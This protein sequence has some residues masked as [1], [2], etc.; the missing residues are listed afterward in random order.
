MQYENVGIDCKTIPNRLSDNISNNNKGNHTKNIRIDIETYNTTCLRNKTIDYIDNSSVNGIPSDV[1]MNFSHSKTASENKVQKN[2]ARIRMCIVAKHY[3]HIKKEYKH[4]ISKHL[5][6]LINLRSP[7]EQRDSQ[8]PCTSLHTTPMKDMFKSEKD[9]SQPK[10]SALKDASIEKPIDN[11][12]PNNN[13]P[14]LIQNINQYT[15][16]I[17]SDPDQR[18]HISQLNNIRSTQNETPTSNQPTVQGPLTK[19]IKT[20]EKYGDAINNNK[21]KTNKKYTKC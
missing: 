4:L 3:D 12:Q 19:K 21:V 18:T 10:Y 1:N 17:N 9:E 5:F 15:T 8:L 14:N 2:T 11:S 7:T 13:T 6:E 16:S 20:Y